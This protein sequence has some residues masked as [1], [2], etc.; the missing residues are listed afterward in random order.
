MFL[1]MCVFISTKQFHFAVHSAAFLWLYGNLVSAPPGLYQAVRNK[2][3]LDIKKT[4][5]L[6]E[7]MWHFHIN[8]N[9]NTVAR[10]ICFCETEPSC[11]T[12]WCLMFFWGFQSV[13]QL[14]A[15]WTNV[16]NSPKCSGQQQAET[17]DPA[18]M[19]VYKTPAKWNTNR[20]YMLKVTRWVIF[21]H[22]R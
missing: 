4:E 22:I 16:W 15:G 2:R 7:T 12:L 19:W 20:H 9:E 17:I 13:G 1:Q 10:L 5:V 8:W 6:F 14:I 3:I 11:E 21:S 18:H